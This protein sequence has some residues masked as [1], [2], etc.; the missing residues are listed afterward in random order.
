MTARYLYS[1]AKRDAALAA[2]E[3]DAMGQIEVDLLKQVLV[4][5]IASGAAPFVGAMDAYTADLACMCSVHTRW[6]ASWSSPLIGVRRS[7]DDTELD[8]LPYSTGLLNTDE[9]L[10]FTGAGDGFI[11][12]VY[13]QSGNG[14]DMVQAIAASQPMIVSSGSVV[15]NQSLPAAALDTAELQDMGLADSVAASAWI[16]TASLTAGTPTYAGLITANPAAIVFVDSGGILFP[17]SMPSALF[18]KDSVLSD[19]FITAFTESGT[20]CWTLTGDAT[21][22]AWFWG[23]ERQNPARYMNGFVQD[24]ILYSTIPSFRADVEAA[25]IARLGL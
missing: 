18:Y 23:S 16:T 4:A 7:S 13:D 14:N 10:A 12:T 3:G 8:I 5:T 19:P 6:L 15:I 20:H 9:L 2:I 25:L 11:T 24:F 22:G 17:P 1:S 21:S